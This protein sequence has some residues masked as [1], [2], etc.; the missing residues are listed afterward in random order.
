ME[1]ELAALA[2]T[3]H[4]GPECKCVWPVF[5]TVKISSYFSPFQGQ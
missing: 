2:G 3:V 5:P 1:K 4:I